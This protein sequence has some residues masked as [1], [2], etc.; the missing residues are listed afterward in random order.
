M[1]YQITHIM[2]INFLLVPLTIIAAACGNGNNKSDAYGNFEAVEIQVSSEV[3]GKIIELKIEEGQQ[4]QNGQI[5]AII[6]TTQL[7][8][9]KMQMIAQMNSADARLLQIQSQIAVQDE[10][11]K[12]LEREQ[13]RLEKL[14]SANAA[15][16]KQLD[17]INGELDVLNSQIVSTRIQNQSISFDIKALN[18]QIAQTNDQLNKSVIR[19]PINGTILEKYVESGEVV[20]PGKI[21]YKVAD[22]SV[23]RLR[24][25]ISGDQLPNVKI[26]EK[27]VVLI[28][29]DKDRN[30]KLEGTVSWISQEAEFTPKIIQT[31]DE[32]VNLVY[33]IKVDVP[34]DG[35][36]KIGMPGE[37]KF[38]E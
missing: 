11:K 32:R 6:D 28:D 33:A 35:S 7:Y 12:S 27:V 26:G 3:Q 19:N 16:S 23:L 17:D 21:L 36:L 2:K 37:V 34:N 5:A 13:K 38:N 18:F 31:K 29:K 24:A 14:V 8:L 9:K 15:P 10:Q 20:V 22:L 30:R 25:Y 4:F 1:H